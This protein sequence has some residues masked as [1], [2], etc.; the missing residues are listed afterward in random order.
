[1]VGGI[2]MKKYSDHEN[3][4]SCDFHNFTKILYHG[5]LELYGIYM[6][7]LQLSIVDKVNSRLR[8][9]KSLNISASWRTNLTGTQSVLHASN[10]IYLVLKQRVLLYTY[11]SRNTY[12]SGL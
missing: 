11:R 3:L 2:I 4:H 12:F 6:H 9:R 1:M 5:N 7:L 10:C 8:M